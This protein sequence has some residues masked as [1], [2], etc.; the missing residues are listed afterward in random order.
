MKRTTSEIEILLVE[1]N[2]AD[3]EL[4]IRT[5]R[6]NHLANRLVWV[7]DGAQALDFL[8]ARGT[9]AGRD[10]TNG[11]AVILLDLRLP[12]VDGLEVLKQMKSDA[13]TRSI[14]VV[15]LSSSTE[16]Q[17]ILRTYEL[18]GNSYVTKPVQ[19]EDFARSVQQLGL[20]WLLINKAPELGLA[21][22]RR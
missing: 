3:A 10:T 9:F 21:R 17:D 4:T 19:F 6:K 2:A 7:R 11:P 8:Y 14:P 22:D 18:G 20:Y 16:E 13:R 1:D 15:V 12:K 5:L